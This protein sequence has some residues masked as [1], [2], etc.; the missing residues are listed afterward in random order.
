MADMSFPTVSEKGKNMSIIG[1]KSSTVTATSTELTSTVV[2]TASD[3]STTLI[4]YGSKVI[5]NSVN[6]IWEDMHNDTDCTPAA[7][8][9]MPQ[10]TGALFT[11][12]LNTYFTR[13]TKANAWHEIEEDA[14]KGNYCSYGISK[15]TNTQV[16]LGRIFAAWL[17]TSGVWHTTID[18]NGGWKGATQPHNMIFSSNR[19]C[20]NLEAQPFKDLRDYQYPHYKVFKG[21]SKNGYPL[22]EPNYTY[23]YHGW[24]GN[25]AQYIDKSRI[26]AYFVTM[27]VRLVQKDKDKPNDFHKARFIIHC[28]ADVK[29]DDGTSCMEQD[30][31]GKWTRKCGQGVGGISR[32]KLIPQNGNWMPIN[33][34][35][36]WITKDELADNP[37]PFPTKP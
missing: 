23:R 22:Y 12:Q 37:P 33:F 13:W 10:S 24:N 8:G 34:L 28:S 7:T 5:P 17:D 26:K 31:N 3:E 4:A 21:Y 1:S 25:G 30:I 18:G 20:S 9:A 2:S 15:S 6:L 16:E 14:G 36:G 11:G 29:A 35:D 19:A 27:Y 32:Y